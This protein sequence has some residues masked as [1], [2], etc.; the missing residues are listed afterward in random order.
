MPQGLL[1]ETTPEGILRVELHKSSGAE[2][3][4]E[5]DPMSEARV[6]TI[7]A[8]MGS[9]GI[10]SF[11]HFEEELAP[12]NDAVQVATVQMRT[13]LAEKGISDTST[14]LDGRVV[15]NNQYNVGARFKA[16]QKFANDG[17]AKLAI[18]ELSLKLLPMLATA[19]ALNPGQTIY[20]KYS[21]VIVCLVDEDGRPNGTQA[22]SRSQLFL[23]LPEEYLEAFLSA[24]NEVERPY[25]RYNREYIKPPNVQ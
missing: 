2:M 16:L 6:H 19:R 1:R 8:I 17:S 7:K 4:I 21:P 25:F 22:A 14:K 12:I 20:W 23:N 9:K 13:V 10:P 18:P 11:E 5:C 15:P 3:V 24:H